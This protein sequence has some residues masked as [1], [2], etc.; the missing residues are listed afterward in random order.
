MMMKWSHCSCSLSRRIQTEHRVLN[1]APKIDKRGKASIRWGWD[2]ETVHAATQR[3]VPK[4][5]SGSYDENI[6]VVSFGPMCVSRQ[7]GR[8]FCL[9]IRHIHCLF[10]FC[11]L[12]SAFISSKSHSQA[13]LYARLSFCFILEAGGSTFSASTTFSGTER[14]ATVRY[15][16]NRLVF[17]VRNAK[18]TLIC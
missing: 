4:E 1:F 14:E 2:R 6:A 12:A 17:S 11:P 3:H 5:A 15:P 7:N 8:R 10:S 16:Y 18:V 9:F 13:L